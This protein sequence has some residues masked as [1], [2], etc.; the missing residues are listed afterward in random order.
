MWGPREG[1]CS[2]EAQHSRLPGFRGFPAGRGV[3][4]GLGGLEAPWG[5]VPRL[6]RCPLDDSGMLLTHP[7]R[8][9]GQ[10]RRGVFGLECI[11]GGGGRN[12]KAGLY[13][14][15]NAYLSIYIYMTLV[16]EHVWGREL[17]S[18]N[19]SNRI[20]LPIRKTCPAPTRSSEVQP[21]ICNL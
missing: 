18:C 3:P 17:S 2:G 13:R 14:I 10:T 4:G 7:G 1:W 15:L 12:K 16:W 20:S 8:L 5:K 19:P 9:W 11:G 21:R 6:A